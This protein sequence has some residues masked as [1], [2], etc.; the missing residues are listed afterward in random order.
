MPPIDALLTRNREFAASGAHADVEIIPR[1]QAMIITC[2]DF[3]VDPAAFLGVGHGDAMVLRNTGGRVARETIEEV[4]YIAHLFEHIGGDQAPPFEVA[5]VHHTDCGT[6]FLADDAF[7][8]SFADLVGAEPA[9]LAERAVTDPAATVR[10][11]VERLRTSELL[12]SLVTVSGHVYDLATGLVET[13]ADAS[14]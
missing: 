14:A 2:L 8:E 10:A 9:R 7:R 4:A 1:Q 12:P 5:V 6:R 11:D 3:R 13:I